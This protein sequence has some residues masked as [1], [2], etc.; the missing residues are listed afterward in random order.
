MKL[1]LLQWGGETGR[2]CGKRKALRKTGGPTSTLFLII[3]VFQVK[4]GQKTVIDGGEKYRNEGQKRD[5]T[6]Q[7]IKCGKYLPH[8]AVQMI[9]RSHPGQDHSRIEKC[10]DPGKPPQ[11]MI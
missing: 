8:G 3:G 1:A 10:V 7:G 11:Q 9:D 4:P 6:E 2:F 5:A